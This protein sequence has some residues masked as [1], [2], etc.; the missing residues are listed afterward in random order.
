[1]SPRIFTQVPGPSN[2]PALVPPA[3][4]DTSKVKGDKIEDGQVGFLKGAARIHT[5]IAVVVYLWRRG[6]KVG[7]VVLVRSVPLNIIYC[8]ET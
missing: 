7:A 1:M 6:D 2:F 3:S 5:A 4:Q 8:L